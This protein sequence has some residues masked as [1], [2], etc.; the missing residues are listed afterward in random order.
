MDFLK[1]SHFMLGPDPRL[2]LGAMHS[3]SHRDFPSHPVATRSRPCQQL[4]SALF[5]LDR[6]WA[7]KEQGSEA[8]RAF[9]PPLATEQWRE[10]ERELARART[11][12][13]Q[14]SHLHLHAD[15]RAG[16]G[17]PTVR[18]DYAWVELP[19]RA[20]E[21]IRGARLIFDR[22]SVPPGDPAKLRIPPTT[23]QE[24]FPPHDSWPQLRT[25]RGNQSCSLSLSPSSGGPNPLKWDQRGQD[26]ETSYQRQFQALPSPPASMCKR[27]SSSVKMGDVK[28]GYGPVC[29]EQKQAYGPQG[30]PPDSYDKAKA[31][32]NTHCV[33]IRPGDGLFRHRTSMA[34]HFYAHEPGPSVLHHDQTPPSHILEG[35]WRPGPGSLTTLTR[36][37]HGQ[38]PPATSPPSRHQPHEKLR[39]HVVLGEPAL[40][41]QFFQTSV[42]TDYC[43]PRTQQLV[44]ALSLHLQHSNLP[45]GTGELDFQTTN[46]KML[47]PHRTAPASMTE[48]M[49]QRCK[50]SHMEP[51][52]GRQ[53]FLSTHYN[54]NFTFKY[55]G[56]VV[57]R[58]DNSQ[59]SY[60][61]L[62]TS[63]QWG[64]GAGKA[65]PQAP[66]APVYPC[67]SQQ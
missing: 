49:L 29:S 19:A 61:P 53:H 66:Q 18:S 28:T 48:E 44:K 21:R 38:P 58:A 22:D 52:L 59:E 13:M 63:R 34:D 33:N 12:D 11:R 9:V 54:D 20:R 57:L 47:K 51:P 3:T 37:F 7:D 14:A 35:N 6:A 17:L 36:F 8:H 60:V 67:P 31:S 41:S 43:P 27:A 56:P 26:N 39:T 32:A 40:R 45:E 50:Y 62:G 24:Q 5:Q 4:R 46:Q 15:A 1:A 2:N 65:D 30:L 10:Q 42:G 23:Y 16:T 55:Q 64:C 25:P